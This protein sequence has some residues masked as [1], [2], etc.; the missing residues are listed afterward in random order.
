MDFARLYAELGVDPACGIDG[1]RA[2][3]R[4][5]ASRLH[6]DAGGG[7]GEIA[8][9]QQLNHAYHAATRFHREHGRLPG[10]PG[11]AGRTRATPPGVVQAHAVERRVVAAPR[12]NLRSLM[13]VGVLIALAAWIANPPRPGGPQQAKAGDGGHGAAGGPPA[14]GHARVPARMAIGMSPAMVLEVSGKPLARS[15]R[16]W[17]YGPSWIGYRCGVVA[18]WYSSPLRPLHDGPARPREIDIAGLPD[19]CRGVGK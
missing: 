13:L 7:D 11:P 19:S 3:Y 8:R 2:A 14:Q 16:R 4:R 9:L 6:P 10:E 17:D 15:A 18:D 1:L 5:V 12:R